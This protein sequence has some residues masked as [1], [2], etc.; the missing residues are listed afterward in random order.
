MKLRMVRFPAF[1]TD[2]QP[3]RFALNNK[4]SKILQSVLKTASIADTKSAFV[5]CKVTH[6]PELS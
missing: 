2:F 1:I 3:V 4:L 6:D 5:G